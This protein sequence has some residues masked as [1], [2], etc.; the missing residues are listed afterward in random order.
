MAEASLTRQEHGGNHRL[1]L[2]G[3]W[4]LLSIILASRMAFIDAS[5]LNVA[6]P[7]L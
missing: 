1:P 5:A 4:F 3:R 6:L 2:I 7:A